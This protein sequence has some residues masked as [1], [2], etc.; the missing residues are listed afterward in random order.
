MEKGTWRIRREAL[1]SP[2]EARVDRWRPAEG[3]GSHAEWGGEEDGF[4]AK[5]LVVLGYTMVGKDSSWEGTWSRKKNKD[6]LVPASTCAS[7]SHH[8]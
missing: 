1:V 4:A 5:H 3:P 7:T 6:K 8:H 2:P